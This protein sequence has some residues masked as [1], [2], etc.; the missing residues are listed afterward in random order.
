MSKNNIYRISF[1]NQ[2]S[3][4][5]LYAKKV[6]HDA[7]FGFV[8]LSDF[9]FGAPSSLVVDPSVERMKTEFENVKKTF[10][11][12]HSVLRIDEVEKESVSKM[13]D[14]PSSKGGSNI[15]HFPMPVYTPSGPSP[16]GEKN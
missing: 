6:N 3:I 13:K 14:I 2:G 10:I 1:F 9:I 12:L 16:T 11:P 7:L 5:E 8:E 4:Y 15:A